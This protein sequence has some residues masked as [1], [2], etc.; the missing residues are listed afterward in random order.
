MNFVGMLSIDSIEHDE[1]FIGQLMSGILFLLRLMGGGQC[2]R[3][4]AGI[5]RKNT[6]WYNIVPISLHRHHA[7]A[8][9][10]ICLNKDGKLRGG[11]DSGIQQ[12]GMVPSA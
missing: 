9:R 11:A 12:Y 5:G 6:I 2:L 1:K 10:D 7:M 4:V 8:K 3:A